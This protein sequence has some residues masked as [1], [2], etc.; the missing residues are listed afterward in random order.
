LILPVWE[1]PYR[2]AYRI[3]KAFTA[4]MIKVKLFYKLPDMMVGEYVDNIEY[5]LIK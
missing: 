4:A 1:F 2:T 5:E 3:A